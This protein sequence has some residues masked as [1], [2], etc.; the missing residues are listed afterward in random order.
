M[1]FD[2]PTNTWFH[3]P[4]ATSSLPLSFYCTRLPPP[5]P[6]PCGSPLFSVLGGTLASVKILHSPV[7][8]AAGKPVEEV[9]RVETLRQTKVAGLRR[10]GGGGEVE[11]GGRQSG[12]AGESEG[13]RVGGCRWR[14][15][16]TRDRGREVKRGLG[17]AGDGDAGRGGGGEGCGVGREGGRDAG[18]GGGEGEGYREDG[19]ERREGRK[20]VSRISSCTTF[21]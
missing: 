7:T 15:G 16:G 3:S 13:G 21:S 18:S 8:A 10:L 17:R 19:E 6:A 4:V 11:Q 2:A 9:Q 1:R 14:Q 5:P 12:S 20:R